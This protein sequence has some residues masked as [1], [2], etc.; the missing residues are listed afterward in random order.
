VIWSTVPARVSTP[1]VTDLS[2]WSVTFGGLILLCQI[3]AMEMH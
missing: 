2:S 1:A 3:D